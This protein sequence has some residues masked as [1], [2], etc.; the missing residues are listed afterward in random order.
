MDANEMF[1][2]ICID[3]ATMFYRQFGSS[4]LESSLEVTLEFDELQR[5]SKLVDLKVDGLPKLPP[6]EF[7]GEI[8]K[9][10]QEF[11]ALPEI[12]KLKSLAI[13]IK[14]GGKLNTLPIYLK[15]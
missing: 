11:L 4:N 13:D 6:F 14:P 5:V 9:K 8:N 15:S 3:V 1:S 2:Q 10:C 7:L 12:Y